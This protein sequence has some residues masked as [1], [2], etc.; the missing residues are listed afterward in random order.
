MAGGAAL[1]AEGED[2]DFKFAAFVFDVE[3]VAVRTSREGLA[4]CRLR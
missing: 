3:H 2:L 4:G 1:L